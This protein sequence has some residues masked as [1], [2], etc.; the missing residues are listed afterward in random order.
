MS[1]PDSCGPTSVSSSPSTQSDEPTRLK[2]AFLIHSQKTL[3]ENLPP[4]VDNK[5]LARQKRRRTRYVTRDGLPALRKKEASNGP[6]MLFG[7]QRSRF[8]TRSSPEDHAV[9]EA[10]YLKNPKPD[11]TARADIV[12]RVSL[13]EKE[14][15]VR[16]GVVPRWS[17]IP[18]GMHHRVSDRICLCQKDLVSESSPERPSQIEAIRSPRAS[19]PQFE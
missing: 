11:K 8:T 9:L 19:R 13:G 1:D 14:V 16:V 7:H 6:G 4:R 10:E 18:V 2:Y 17:S 3:T 5:L 15:Q 12:S